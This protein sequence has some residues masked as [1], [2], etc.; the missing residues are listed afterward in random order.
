M[1][2]ICEATCEGTCSADLS[3]DKGDVNGEETGNASNDDL[4][5][6]E[7]GAG[8]DDFLAFVFTLDLT[9]WLKQPRG[10]TIFPSIVRISKDLIREICDRFLQKVS[11]SSNILQNRNSKLSLAIFLFSFF[12]SLI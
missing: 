3:N 6:L 12:S 7:R 9:I 4:E 1:V 10:L 8:G 5:G 2:D 11:K